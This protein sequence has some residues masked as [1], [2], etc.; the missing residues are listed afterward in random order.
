MASQA[1]LYRQRIAKYSSDPTHNPKVLREMLRQLDYANTI[2]PDIS[3][4]ASKILNPPK[5]PQ[6]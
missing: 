1:E 3:K 5:S 2:D 6:G 4:Q